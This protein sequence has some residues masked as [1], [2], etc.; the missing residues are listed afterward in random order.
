MDFSYPVSTSPQSI[1]FESSMHFA[2]VV[3]GRWGKGCGVRISYHPTTIEV[4]IKTP[5]IGVNNRRLR[6][7]HIMSHL[8][9]QLPM[10]LVRDV[11]AHSSV[12]SDVSF[13]Q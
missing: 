8:D 4:E 13:K 1:H 10:P 11:F 6:V 3:G 9:A 2:N 7:S 12:A 5:D